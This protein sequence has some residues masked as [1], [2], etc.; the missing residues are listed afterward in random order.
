[1]SVALTEDLT[2]FQW[3]IIFVL[4]GG[5]DY[6]LGIKR[7]LEENYGEEVQHGRLYPNVDDLVDLGLVEKSALDKRTN[8]YELTDR[9][10]AAYR[11]RVVAGIEQIGFEFTSEEK[12]R[13]NAALDPAT[14]SGDD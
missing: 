2:R 6:G 11:Q 13:I 1:M 7:S 4:A 10:G 3:D 12:E 14:S 8:Q 5:S 9:G